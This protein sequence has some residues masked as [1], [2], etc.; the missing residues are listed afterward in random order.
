MASML[1]IRSKL[2][3]LLMVS[4]LAAALAISSI[5]Y[6]RS[7]QALRAAVWDQLLAVRETKKRPTSCG[8]WIRKNVRLPS[9][10]PKVKRNKPCLNFA[11][12][13]RQRGLC[14]RRRSWLR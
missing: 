4:G 6:V 14:H 5:G 8:I 2:L 12:H 7:D 9:W 1:S 11:R 3:L 13:E 10:R